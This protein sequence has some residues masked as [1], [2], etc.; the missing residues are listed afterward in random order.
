[1]AKHVTIATVLL[2][3]TPMLASSQG[4]MG[5]ALMESNRAALTQLLAQYDAVMRSTA[6]SEVLRAEVRGQADSIRTRLTMGDFRVGDRVA[7][8]VESEDALQWDTLLINAGP[9]ID[10]PTVGVI[11]LRGV[12][13]SELESHLTTEI[14]QYIQTPRVSA[15]SLIQLAVIG[16]GRP[17]FYSIPTDAS[18][19][20]VVMVTGGPALGSAPDFMRIERGQDVLW[21]VEDLIGPVANARTLDQLGLQAGDRI[22]LA[23]D[24]DLVQPGGESRVAQQMLQSAAL[25]V[26]P[27]L[28][29]LGIR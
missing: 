19:S 3:A 1:M 9:E 6:Y 18:L 22:I 2:L 21:S 29:R 13:R 28:L 4:T 8:N 15:R 24:P 20:D 14:A 16:V 10:V 17:G 5:R 26:L 7:L 23:A 25:L 12:L 11:S 27:I